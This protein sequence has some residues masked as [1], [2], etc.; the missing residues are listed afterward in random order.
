MTPSK[1]EFPY[2][3]AALTQYIVDAAAAAN[4]IIINSL[5]DSDKALIRRCHTIS[6]TQKLHLLGKF[7]KRFAIVVAD[8]AKVLDNP[9]SMETFKYWART[10]IFKMIGPSL[11]SWGL[12]V[13]ADKEILQSLSR[14]SLDINPK[15]MYLLRNYTDISN[16]ISDI[17]DSQAKIA[18]QHES[19]NIIDNF[20]SRAFSVLMSHD[21]KVHKRQKINKYQIPI[22]F[23]LS[24]NRT[25]YVSVTEMSLNLGSAEQWVYKQMLDMSHNGIVQGEYEELPPEGGARKLYQ[26]TGYGVTIL[27]QLRDRITSQL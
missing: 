17:L 6:L 4:E 23:Y 25:R 10:R 16:N 13:R 5:S 1:D 2:Y 11:K 8:R 14:L 18:A 21:N 24:V 27:N 15:T 9:F 7:G 22:L 19:Q 3:D 20:L 12:L 26:L